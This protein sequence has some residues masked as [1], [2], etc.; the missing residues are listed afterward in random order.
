MTSEPNTKRRS[1]LTRSPL[2]IASEKGHCEIVKYLVAQNADVN[3]TDG[4]NTSPLYSAVKM[5]H[6]DIVEFLL[7]NGADVNICNHLGYLPLYAAS[8]SGHCAIFRLLIE[9]GALSA[10]N[11]KSHQAN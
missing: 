9:H 3:L 4:N 1:K 6:Y 8:S 7:Q 10:G 11:A 2:L 5:G